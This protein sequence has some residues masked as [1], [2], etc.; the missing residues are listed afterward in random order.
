MPI[1]TMKVSEASWVA[2]PC[3][4]RSMVPIQPIS[5]DV[6]EN[7]PTST[8]SVMAIGQP[9]LTISASFGQSERHSRPNTA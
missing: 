9:S 3:A 1:G 8:S 6:P 4:A 5:T 2:M 7:S